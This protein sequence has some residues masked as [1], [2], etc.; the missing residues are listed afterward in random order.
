MNDTGQATKTYQGGMLDAPAYGTYTERSAEYRYAIE[1]A[2]HHGLFRINTPVLDVGC[3]DPFNGFLR[4]LRAFCWDGFYV[5]VDLGFDPNVAMEGEEDDKVILL[6]QSVD[7]EALPFPPSDE[8]PFKQFATGFLIEVA[9]KLANWKSAV[10]EMQRTCASVVLI[11]P[12]ATFVG[13][14][15]PEPGRVDAIAPEALKEAGF[16]KTGC[17]NLNGRPRPGGRLYDRDSGVIERSSEVWGVW[18]DDRA[19][20]LNRD[21]EASGYL[22]QMVEGVGR[23]H[24][25]LEDHEL[26]EDG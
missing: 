4:F 7:G 24:R 5:G 12:N 20:Y 19:T 3:A 2:F 26:K 25:V 9:D 8:I 15:Q 6:E 14:R 23:V 17:I 21:R 11:G 13:W 18:C 22:Y 16:Q 10:A 1:L